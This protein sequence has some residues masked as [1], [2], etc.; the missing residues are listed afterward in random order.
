MR[1]KILTLLACSM[2]TLSSSA[3]AA[4]MQYDAKSFKAAQESGKTIALEF[5]ASWCPTCKA[6]NASLKEIETQAAFKDVVFVT[7]DFD[8]DTELKKAFGVTGQSAFVVLAGQKEVNRSTGKTA[9]AD[10]SK[11]VSEGITA[12]SA[13]MKKNDSMMKHED[14]LMKKDDGMM[15]EEDGMMKK[16]DAMMKK[17]M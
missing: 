6:Q 17:D 5:F 12:N 15:K 16:D 14:G 10:L 11:Q 2:L 3:W 1:T 7:A 13:M 8:K 4:T 9:A